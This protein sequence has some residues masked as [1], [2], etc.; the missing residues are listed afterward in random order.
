M[1]KG[2]TLP[3]SAADDLSLSHS[4]SECDPESL[5]AL[6]PFIAALRPDTLHFMELCYTFT[7]LGAA[8]DKDTLLD[9]T[10]KMLVRVSWA[11]VRKQ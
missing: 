11:A 4:P 8:Q 3:S 10:E 7:L 5:L 2:S 6:E 9:N 1:F